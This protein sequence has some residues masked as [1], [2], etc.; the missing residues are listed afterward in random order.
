M[1]K[2]YIDIPS[3]GFTVKLTKKFEVAETITTA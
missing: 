3:D 1:D 2:K